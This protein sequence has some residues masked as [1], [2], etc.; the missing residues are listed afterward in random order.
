[1]MIG[2]ATAANALDA[3][4]TSLDNTSNNLANIN[5]T[6][7]KRTVVSF[8]D[9]SYTGGPNKQIGNGVRVASILPTGFAQGSFQSTGNQ[10]DVAINGTGFIQV[11]LPDGSIEYS[12]D[13]SLHRDNLNRLVTNAGYPI[14]PAVTF[15]SDTTS[16]TI[17]TD[18]TISVLTAA[19]PNTPKVI[20]QFQ[21]ATF[22]N[23]EALQVRSR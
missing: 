2:L 16:I 20:G 9:F 21:L 6:A 14:V 5:T 22:P 19:S 23:Q 18:G 12:R 13:G 8:Q 10:T 11:Q 3:Y 1:M 17:T 4:Q 7:F 15:P